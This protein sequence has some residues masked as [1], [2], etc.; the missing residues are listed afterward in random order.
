M[1]CLLRRQACFIIQL[2]RP[3]QFAFGQQVPK[4]RSQDLLKQ[5]ADHNGHR[6]LCRKKLVA[7]TAPAL[8]F[9]IPPVKIKAT[10]SS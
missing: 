6:Y 9:R 5:H 3:F 10:F 2:I 1:P 8:I 4:Q 7:K